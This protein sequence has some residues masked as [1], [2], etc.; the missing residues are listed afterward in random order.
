MTS[1]NT[2]YE[3]RIREALGKPAAKP[4]AISS[5]LSVGFPTVGLGSGFFSQIAPY[6][7]YALIATFIIMLILV[8][9]HYTVKP[10]FNFGD[11][12]DALINITAPD[13]TKS[14]SDLTISNI[15]LP[16]STTLPMNNYSFL[17]DVYINDTKSV[18][19]TGNVYVLL[20]KT[21]GIPEATA[22][23]QGVTYTDLIE[24]SNG[25]KFKAAL[26]TTFPFLDTSLTSGGTGSTIP[27]D[28]TAP[29]LVLAYN[30]L[31]GK[32]FVYFITKT[33]ATPYSK[34]VDVPIQ[35]NKLYRVGVVVTTSMV[36]LYLDGQYANSSIYPGQTIQGTENDILI[37]TP[38]VFSDK[39]RV[40]NLFTVPRTVSSGEIRGMGGPSSIKLD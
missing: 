1:I 22:S 15:D 6:L 12:P 35:P 7:I 16:S 2:G 27:T 3:A 17:V 38:N 34:L 20:Y 32:L 10:I 28:V 37:S 29:S 39:V 25:A 24:S 21:A 11:N 23:A 9:I 26:L 13:W 30:S 14:W 33:D 4:I 19:T 8:V 18:A 31:N 40:G 5:G 36:E